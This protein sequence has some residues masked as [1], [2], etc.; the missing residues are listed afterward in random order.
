MEIDVPPKP[1]GPTLRPMSLRERIDDLILR[2]LGVNENEL[3]PGA[4]FTEDLGADSLDL[5]ELEIV[6][7]EEF[8]LPEA[9]IDFDRLTTAQKLYEHLERATGAKKKKR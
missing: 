7:E 5:A 1:K 6:I 8:E 4:R 2:E 3:T 9:S